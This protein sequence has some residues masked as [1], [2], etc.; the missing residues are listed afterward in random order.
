MNAQKQDFNGQLTAQLST[1]RQRIPDFPVDH[2]RIVRLIANVHQ[3]TVDSYN[4]VLRDHGIGYR[5]YAT[6]MTIYTTADYYMTPSEI[7]NALSE[8]KT[9]MTRL[10]DELLAKGLIAKDDAPHDRRSIVL[11][12]TEKGEALIADVAPQI[13]A[14]L[15]AIYDTTETSE[16][17]QLGN[18]LS[19]Q[20][21][22]LVSVSERSGRKSRKE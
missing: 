1:L 21:A 22:S 12:L 11:H 14:L 19:K 15:H 4:D 13:S 10:T 20:L 17:E 9:N 16:R 8:K 3:R 7:A 2:A 6:L 18:S 5:A